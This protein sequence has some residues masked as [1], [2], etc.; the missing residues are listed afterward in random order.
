MQS[1]RSTTIYTAK[2]SLDAAS[3]NFVSLSLNLQVHLKIFLYMSTRHSLNYGLKSQSELM[4]IEKPRGKEVCISWSLIYFFAPNESDDH[5][6]MEVQICGRVIGCCLPLCR[7][8]NSVH[9]L[10][11]EQ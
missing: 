11:K 3:N 9:E 5:S 10:I 4:R 2:I 1:K 6:L 8:R 7:Y